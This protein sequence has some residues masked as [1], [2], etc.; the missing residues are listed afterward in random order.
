MLGRKLARAAIAWG[1]A[2]HQLAGGEQ[3]LHHLFL[4]GFFL[5]FSL[6]LSSSLFLFLFFLFL[7]FYFS[8]SH[9]PFLP[10][11]FHFFLL[12]FLYSFL[13]FLHIKLSLCKHMSFL[14]F[15]SLIL[16]RGQ[17]RSKQAAM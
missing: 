4:T 9:S 12:S 2:G 14:T 6:S 1:L 8:F 17:L 7:S 5:T 10:S 16:S 15:T 11:L 13:S 3:F